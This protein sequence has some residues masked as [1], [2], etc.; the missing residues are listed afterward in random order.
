MV[1]NSI[2]NIW[3]KIFQTHHIHFFTQ[4]GISDFSKD[5]SFLL[6]GMELSNPNPST[7]KTLKQILVCA[8]FG[9]GQAIWPQQSGKRL[10]RKRVTSD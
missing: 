2:I 9:G 1:F 6:V 3:Y 4:H 7:W 8:S 10:R 5:A